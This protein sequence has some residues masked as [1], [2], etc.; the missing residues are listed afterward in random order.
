MTKTI[1]DC[2]DCGVKP[3]QPHEDGC[4]LERC[5]VCGGQ[6]LQCDCKDHDPVFARWTGIWPGAAE[7]EFLDID[8]NTFYANGTYKYFFVKPEE[9]ETKYSVLLLYPEYLCGDYGL[10]VYLAHVKAHQWNWVINRAQKMA[11]DEE[12]IK[13]REMKK[14]G[15]RTDIKI[16]P[17]DFHPLAV[18]E[19]WHELIQSII[20]KKED[21]P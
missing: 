17:E 15:R 6:R 4:D 16:K 11:A 2:L 7:S 9:P 18:I 10:E 12:N 19:G 5:S 13:L 21:L 8:L 1:R 3:G 14:A 20:K